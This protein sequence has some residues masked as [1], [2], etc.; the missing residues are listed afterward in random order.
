VIIGSADPVH[1]KS[2]GF[3]RH[4]FFIFF[5]AKGARRNFLPHYASGTCDRVSY[6]RG[7][8]EVTLQRKLVGSCDRVSYLKGRR[9]G[10]VT[11]EKIV[12]M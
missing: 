4:I 5:L 9:G 7:G 6:Y 12:A 2:Q 11:S 10:D 8:E 3:R 1:I